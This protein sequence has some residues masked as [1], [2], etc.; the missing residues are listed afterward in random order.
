MSKAR[1]S[2]ALLEA[3]TRLLALRES[4]GIVPHDP[5]PFATESAL[6]KG[7]NAAPSRS[8]ELLL[9]RRQVEAK[10]QG[11]RA[12]DALKSTLAQPD[13]H[14]PAVMLPASPVQPSRQVTRPQESVK[15]YPDLAL[16]ML[17]ANLA[18]P[19]RVYWLLKHID[20]IGQ[21]WLSVET[22]R[23]RLTGHGSKL[24]VC[25]W[26]R[27]RQIFSQGENV[28]WRRDRVGRLWLYGVAQVA[29]NLAVERL[30]GNPVS[31]PI[32]NLLGG[33]QAV[34]AHFYACFHSGR[35]KDNPISR[36]QLRAITNVP[37]RTQL[38]YEK[39]AAVTKQQNFAIGE[40]YSQEQFYERA[41]VHGRGT[42]HFLDTK[43]QQGT[44]G[45][46]YV[47]WHLPN[48]YTGPHAKRNKGRQKKINQ[49]LVDLVMKG[50]RGNGWEPVDK[51]FWPHGA[52]AGAAYNRD[53]EHDAYWPQQLTRNRTYHL[54]HVIPGDGR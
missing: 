47:A 18:A 11:E 33:I 5:P 15:I 41:W 7:N 32:K 8:Q 19:G 43:G 31:I 45:R 40:R 44:A 22:I 37:E 50:M 1:P 28:F 25:G 54:W 27:L 34:R 23:D 21:G 53:Q 36:E 52:A 49:R 4:L 17:E 30:T 26:R 14:S 10:L 39:T 29:A 16:G 46:E 13:T 35:R 3:Q 24:K 9:K 2:S 6:G 48:N 38:E 12:S 20:T 51:V 42:F